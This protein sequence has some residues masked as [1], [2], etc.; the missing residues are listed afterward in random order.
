MKSTQETQ[1]NCYI[2]IEIHL[3]ILKS[4]KKY[5]KNNT[6]N[7]SRH[8]MKTYFGIFRASFFV[9]KNIIIFVLAIIDLF[10]S[11]QYKANII[12]RL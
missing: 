1:K 8:S 5:K 7:L 11:I 12:N 9:M 4:S 2:L 10:P 6:K 3:S